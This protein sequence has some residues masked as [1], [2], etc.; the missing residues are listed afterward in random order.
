[1]GLPLQQQP[2][3]SKNTREEKEEQGQEGREKNRLQTDQDPP[4]QPLIRSL[5]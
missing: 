1:M 4:R 3:Q 5:E 2:L